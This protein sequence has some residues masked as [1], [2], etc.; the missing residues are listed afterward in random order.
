MKRFIPYM[1]MFI[2]VLAFLA[3]VVISIVSGDLPETIISV[4]LIVI[5]YF[6]II[7]F[8]IGITL[9]KKRQTKNN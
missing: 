2:G 8:Y 3:T 7:L 1:L 6:G 9:L 5:G 4:G